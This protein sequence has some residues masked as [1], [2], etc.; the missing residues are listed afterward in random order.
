M[1][2]DDALKLRVTLTPPP[3]KAHDTE[4]RLEDVAAQ[5]IEPEGLVTVFWGVIVTVSLSIRIVL[6][7]TP[8]NEYVVT[9]EFIY[10]VGVTE[11]LFSEGTDEIDE[12]TPLLRDYIF[13]VSNTKVEVF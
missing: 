1:L 3:D 5:V 12:N 2:P 6:E 7:I 11:K 4:S 10:E 8:E 9:A 13:W